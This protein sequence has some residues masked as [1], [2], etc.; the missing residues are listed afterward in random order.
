MIA[1]VQFAETERLL[2]YDYYLGIGFSNIY[3]STQEDVNIGGVFTPID[4]DAERGFN[5]ILR[6]GVKI[7]IKVK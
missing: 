1:G 5:P 4:I 6:I 3:I 7:G 2:V